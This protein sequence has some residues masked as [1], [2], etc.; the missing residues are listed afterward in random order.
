M[1]QIQQ[2]VN[3]KIRDDLSVEIKEMPLDEARKSG[4]VMMFGEKYGDRVRVIS[5]GDYS[6]E[7]CGGTH[8]RR[9][10]QIGM[11]VVTAEGSV[12]SGVRR[13]IGQNRPVPKRL[14]RTRWRGDRRGLP[15]KY[16]FE[17][18]RSTATARGALSTSR[19]RPVR[20]S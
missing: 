18:R 13:M 17:S 16:T 11:M 20:V 3:A 9:S 14:S 6:T 7:L 2:I 4:A 15:V 12:S 10:G 19:V 1:Q 5:I 8:L